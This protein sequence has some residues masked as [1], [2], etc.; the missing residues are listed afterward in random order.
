MQNFTQNN[1]SSF[2]VTA[3]AKGGGS[4]F[5]AGGDLI[6][7]IGNMGGNQSNNT[8]TGNLDIYV[9]GQNI[10][11]IH[12]TENAGWSA[13]DNLSYPV[14]FSVE[15]P[16]PLG[17]ISIDATLGA[18]GSVGLQYSASLAPISASFTATPS[19]HTA[20]YAE[21]GVGVYIGSVG[22]YGSLNPILDWNM[23]L[24]ADAGMGW[25]F[26]LYAYEDFYADTDVHML[27]GTFGVY[28]KVGVDPFSHEWDFQLFSEPGLQLSG[29]LVDAKNKIPLNP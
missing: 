19:V 25:L 26:G 11:D 17:P 3:E 9:I 10:L 20:A 4:V 16:I 18:Q 21:I 5:G 6:R 29:V 15:V 1:P 27:A 2:L 28:L 23:N 12:K 8:V 14:D 13:Q 24:H 22:V 7:A